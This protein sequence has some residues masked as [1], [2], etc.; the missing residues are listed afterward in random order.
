[1]DGDSRLHLSF[2]QGREWEGHEWITRKCFAATEIR[3]VRT[4][5][6]YARLPR[7]TGR[8]SVSSGSVA[9]CFVLAPNMQR[10]IGPIWLPLLGVLVES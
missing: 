7:S 2:Q 10:C 1:M 8:E 4:R 6:E 5:L 3:P 9:L